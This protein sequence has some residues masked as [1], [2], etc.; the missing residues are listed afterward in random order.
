MANLSEH[1]HK[2]RHNEVFAA[3]FW[4]ARF[5]YADWAITV[6]FYAAV[7]LVEAYFATIGIHCNNHGQRNQEVTKRVPRRIASHYL[8][9][10]RES[11]RARYEIT[12]MT[13]VYAQNLLVNHFQPLRAYLLSLLP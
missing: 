5:R 3:I 8:R 7:H 9:L 12:P 2:A 10:Y 6:Y 1:I 13:K 4:P 11:R